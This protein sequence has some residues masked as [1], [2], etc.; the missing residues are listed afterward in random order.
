ML[1]AYGV[2]QGGVREERPASGE[3]L[4]GVRL[5]GGGEQAERPAKGDLWSRSRDTRP[6][7]RDSSARDHATLS[8]PRLAS[9]SSHP[10][11]A[12]SSTTLAGSQLACSSP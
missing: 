5:A 4:G 7:F 9:S 3:P 2:E 10:T 11:R 6:R 8:R 1:P 12:A